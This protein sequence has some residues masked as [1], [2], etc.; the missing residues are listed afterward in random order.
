MSAAP[1]GGRVLLVDDDGHL[2]SA[3]K[4]SL[5]LAGYEVR[6]FA[7]AEGVLGQVNR[8]Q[9]L[10]LVTDIKM[11]GSD[12]LELMRRALEIDPD[13]S[14]VLI[15]GHGDIPM[16]VEAMRGGAYDFIEKPFAPEVLI[17]VVRRAMERRG[18]LLQNR[19]LQRALDD[20][21]PL[22]A[23]LLGRSPETESLRGRIE[24]LGGAEVDV[25]LEG[26]TGSGKGLCARLIHQLSERSKGPFVAINSGA[27]PESIIESELFGH[28]AGAFTGAAKQ[29]IGKFEHAN[30][31]TVF[32]D[33]IESMPLESQVRLLRILEERVVERLGSN[34]SQPLDLR[35]I[36]ATKVDLKAAVEQ[37]RF[38]SDLFFRLNVVKLRIPPL[39]ERP[40][41][42]P[43][44]F[45]HFKR[46]A[47]LRLGR[48][49][50]E[51]DAGLLHQLLAHDWPGNVRELQNA[52][53]R[54][55]L[56]FDL[57]LGIEASP[58][59]KAANGL[60]GRVEDFEK[61][62]IQAELER[63]GGNVTATCQSLN[64]PRKTLYE[65]MQKHGIVR[66]GAE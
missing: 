30:G 40:A 50:P 3:C 20:A 64:L 49:A 65:K 60:R 23:H 43:L 6:S 52:A 47:A 38:R 17:G 66:Q 55:A 7:R 42:I 18:L 59:A 44:L 33:E 58:D 24:A 9:A 37:G 62:L 32:L 54:L 12:G 13:L 10:V 28:E 16:A 46:R 61:S 14:V 15:T 27:L 21:G 25:L 53:E 19:E 22:E 26:E 39:R 11:P 34:V 41:D 8:D 51:S 1:P 63:Q 4:Q 5:E 45:E 48:S 35:V 57:D 56:G 36:A 31:G 2:R 29:R